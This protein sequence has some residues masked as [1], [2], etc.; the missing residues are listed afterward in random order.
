[1]LRKF[2]LI[3]S[4]AWAAF[5]LAPVF[6][7]AEAI[8]DLMKT[9]HKAPQG[10]DSVCKKAGDGCATE[11]EL[12][13]LLAGYEAIAVVTPPQGDAG[14]WK[15]K[16]GAVITAIKGLQSGAE[17]AAADFKTAVNC[18]ACHSLHKP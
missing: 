2:L 10:V 6:A 18:K 3:T 17:N 11:A 4:T 1:M 16:T 14:S 9:Y 12:A 8:S 15:E 7:D 13:A 5:S